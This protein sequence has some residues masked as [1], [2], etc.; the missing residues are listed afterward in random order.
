MDEGN[1]LI[2]HSG[3]VFTPP[4]L[5]R[6]ILDLAEYKD[7]RILGKH[8]IDN[9]CGDGAFLCE[10]ADRYCSNY[11]EKHQTADGL[12]GELERYIHGIELDR[13]AWA[14]CRYNLSRL[15]EGYGLYDVEWDVMNAN[16][17]RVSKYDGAMDYVVGNP[18]YVRVHNLEDDY[19][20]VKQY[21]FAQDGMTDLY[22]VFYE[23]GLN[24]LGK[25]G[26][27]C[28]ITPSS[29]LSS[30]AATNMRRYIM[31]ERTLAALVD[32]GHFQAFDGATTYTM[33]A[34]FDLSRRTERIDYYTY[35][36]AMLREEYECSVSYRE[37]C[38][39]GNFYV[40]RSRELDMLH[41]IKASP[42]RKYCTVKNGFATLADKV[43]ILG[44]EFD[45]LTI[46]ILKASTGKW[47]KGFFPYDENGKPLPKEKIFAYPR[48]AAYLNANKDALLKGKKEEA[49]PYWY[50]Y[51]RSQALRDVFEEKYAVNTV[52]RDVNSIKLERVPYG[53]GLYSG[54]YI[55][56]HVPFET[57]ES[58][59]KTETFIGYLRMLKKYKSGGYYT[60]NALD[61]EQYIN[62]VLTSRNEPI[63]INRR[64]DKR[65][66]SEGNIAFV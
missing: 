14:N 36:E 1:R 32:L 55:L 50:L 41:T 64:N 52:I 62:S 45:E 16:A 21:K 33:I 4:F 23:L 42:A 30:V 65:R 20:D 15:A 54:L 7:E 38:I 48:V 35:S 53:S 2:K 3:Q 61:L 17:L 66:F 25:D 51:G 22:L 19:D 24:M 39:G 9:S 18:P 58:I 8:V 63:A 29:W 37:I 43:F 34:L 6:N 47:H 12:K 13:A 44:V 46:P 59:I 28:Y 40:A 57:V 5:V 31:Q 27:L 56:T 26:K 11:I 60:F 10:V 49:N